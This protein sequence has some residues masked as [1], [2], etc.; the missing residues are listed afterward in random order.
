MSTNVVYTTEFLVSNLT[1]KSV[2]LGPTS[3]TVVREIQDVQVKPGPNEV[4]LLGLD[5]YVNVDSIRVDGRGPATITDIQTEKVPR[6]ERFE[7]VCPDDS[8]DEISDTDSEDD[9]GVDKSDLE[10][11]R[12]KLRDARAALAS[13]KDENSSAIT[14]LQFLDRYGNSMRAEQVGLTQMNDF[15]TLYR[16]QRA[17]LSDIH[18]RT[19][20]NITDSGEQVDELERKICRLEITH[21]RAKKAASKEARK[22][23]EKR[24]REKQRKARQRLQE[25][26]E[27]QKFWTYEVLQVIVH[28]DGFFNLTPNSSRRNSVVGKQKDIDLQETVSLSITYVVPLG[29]WSPRYELN[30]ETP[31][32]SGRIV[33]RAE[34]QNVSSETWTDTTVILSTSQT[35]FSSLDERI[36][37]LSAWHVK[38][39]GGSSP[40]NK[41]N[42]ESG[43]ESKSEINAQ[44]T[45]FMEKS[46]A[47]QMKKA[48]VH[49]YSLHAAQVQAIPA[50]AMFP[51]TQG[52]RDAPQTQMAQ[53]QARSRGPTSA[54]AR[55]QGSLFGTSQPLALL[56][57]QEASLSRGFGSG[58]VSLSRTDEEVPKGDALV[59]EDNGFDSQTLSGAS[60]VLSHQESLRQDYGLT[61]T[62]DLPG[63]RTLTPSSVSRRHVIAELDLSA[64]T[65]SHVVVPKL[66]PAAFLKA[67][68]KNTSLVTLLR[69]KAG[70]TV[71]GTFLGS[72]T[73]PA[74]APDDFF[75]LSLGV[76]PSIVVTYAKP[77]VRRSTSGF[78]AKEDSAVF[79]RVCW[80]KNTKNTTVSISVHEQVP[81]SEDE[82]LRINIL[83]PKGLEKEGDRKKIEVSKDQWGTGTVSLGKNR[84]VKW[85]IALQK[86]KD[87]KLVLEYEARIPGGQKIIG[88]D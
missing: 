32:S 87:V 48:R 51:H 19:S 2:T 35:S 20:A 64:I 58:R 86:G 11:A 17:E 79:S 8:D 63:H 26:E 27:R 29:S 12:K 28:L 15:L 69:G 47:L 55:P 31:S 73:L 34:F 45:Q 49:N 6:K 76:D 10:K 59:E 68:I 1:T 71:D 38:L 84:E 60:N 83:E 39:L 88:L 46:A 18:Q 24:V 33:Y 67:R 21:K 7:E 43:L 57:S 81:V 77:T 23:R 37:L 75:N 25:R 5:P 3:A 52:P 85:D 53:D 65:L 41:T 16:M 80:I 61:T 74:C 62:Y 14:A 40:G 50:S 13:L 78:F 70:M 30:I 42:W 36:P 82:R 54:P 56:G 9:F 22:S 66:R 72:I 44:N 4:T